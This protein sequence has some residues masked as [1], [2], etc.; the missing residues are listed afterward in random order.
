MMNPKN[1][2]WLRTI[3]VGAFAVF[4]TTTAVADPALLRIGDQRGNTR[5]ILEAAGELK[6]VP[7]RLEWS[8]FPV[9]A[10][11]VEAMNAGAVD[12]GY[13]GDA[14]T[15]FGLAGGAPIKTINV[16]TFDG[17]GSAILV[18][19]EAGIRKVPDLRGKKIAVVKGSPGHL[20][21]AA[22]LK[23]S[24]LSIKDVTLVFL[25]AADAKA[26]LVSG[27]IDAWAIWDPYVSMEELRDHMKVLVSSNAVMREVEC[28][29][30]SDQAIATKRPEL[31]DFIARVRRAYQWAST[32]R[33]AF[34]RAYARDT[35]LPLDV[36]Q[37][38]VSRWGVTVLPSV[39]PQA[40]A[41]HQKVADLYYEIGIIPDR[42]DISKAYDHSFVI[43]DRK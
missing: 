36:A 21:V 6:N 23:K 22:A 12:F 37:R 20:L 24:G 2:S 18:R 32:H 8:V 28:G 27:S 3:G 13:V 35:N 14:T 19:P 30:A 42:L 5:S 41:L 7:Y 17:A 33:D 16:W 15:T 43:L 34:A 39:T 31:L 11:L 40:I 26:A 25:S 29:I 9:G 1:N 38:M 4:F 10:P